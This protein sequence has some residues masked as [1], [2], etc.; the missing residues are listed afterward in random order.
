MTTSYQAFGQ[1]T[2]QLGDEVRTLTRRRESDLLALL[3]VAQGRPVSA[4]RILL[5]LWG[6][7]ALASGPAS[8]QVTVSRLRAW[9]DPERSGPRPIV[10]HPSGLRPGGEPGRRRRLALRGA[11]GAVVGRTHA[12]RAA[13]ARHPGE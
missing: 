3:I 12:S 5:E 10:A 2:A 1:M 4:D 6:A 11:G 13:G 8:V 9:L 7:E